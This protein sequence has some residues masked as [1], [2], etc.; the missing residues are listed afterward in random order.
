MSV[1]HHRVRQRSESFCR[2]GFTLVE[3]LVVIAIIGVLVGLL[4]PAVQAAREAARRMSCSNNLKQVGIAIHNYHAAY[5]QLPRQHGGTWSDSNAPVDMNNR[6][7]LSFLVGLT[8]FFEQQSV[9]EQ[10]TNRSQKRVDGTLQSPP[11]PAMGP[12]PY[13]DQYVPWRTEIPTLRCPSDPGNGAPSYG[14]TNY[15]ACMGDSIDFMDS[16]P[17]LIDGNGVFVRPA[18]TWV[19]IRTRAACRGVFVPRQD[20]KFRDILDGLSHTV[21]CGEIA[22]DL[23]DRNVRTIAAIGNADSV[24]R[25][26]DHCFEAGFIS[27]ARPSFWSDGNDGGTLPTL[28]AAGEGRGYRWA[29][30]GTV[31]TSCN[32]ILPPNREI[33]LGVDPG[34][35]GTIGFGN[36]GPRPSGGVSI[37]APGIATVSSQ[38]QGGAH[39]LMSDGAIIFITDSVDAGNPHVGNVWQ[40][41]TG[42]SSPGYG[43][44]YGLWGALGTRAARDVV[45][46][47]LN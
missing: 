2:Q 46:E 17:V 15:A 21:M 34:P 41:G 13:L 38:H 24:L 44:P 22:T 1:R 25:E 27:P 8:P 33:C 4:L 9:W 43:S 37:E 12:A 16:G 29:Q 20:T 42:P 47:D 11:F 32:T 6:M 10:I 23:G 3:L 7:M 18:P 19:V 14:R 28:A 5:Q 31:W 35:G 40:H 39:I 30:A 26:P 36:P 45:D